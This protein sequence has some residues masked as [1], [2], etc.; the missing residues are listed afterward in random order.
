VITEA[1][2]FLGGVCNPDLG[3][4]N[5]APISEERLTVLLISG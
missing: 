4:Q 2:R 3:L 5:L 1:F